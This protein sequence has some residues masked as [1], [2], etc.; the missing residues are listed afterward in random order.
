MY[1]T[2]R[3]YQ[4]LY[5][6]WPA[7]LPASHYDQ[8]SGLADVSAVRGRSPGVALTSAVR[9]D[10]PRRRPPTH[11]KGYSS[12]ETTQQAL[13]GGLWGVLPTSDADIPL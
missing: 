2:R 8:S 7:V 4:L 13:A 9:R 10:C 5:A 11:S 3:L 6:R 12:P 1:L